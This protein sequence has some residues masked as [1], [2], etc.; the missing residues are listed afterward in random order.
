MSEMEKKSKR[1]EEEKLITYVVNHTGPNW[2]PWII[3]KKKS[4]K[5][6][7]QPYLKTADWIIEHKALKY[8]ELFY[9]QKKWSREWKTEQISS[10]TG[11]RNHFLFAQMRKR[12]STI[13][14]LFALICFSLNDQIIENTSS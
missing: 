13:F 3:K 1:K 5:N 11:E 12:K 10:P 8:K 6:K 14:G 2:F 9:A 7:M 4:Y